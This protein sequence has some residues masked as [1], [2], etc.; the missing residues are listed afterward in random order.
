M[1][2]YDLFFTAACICYNGMF[3]SQFIVFRSFVPFEMK[4]NFLFQG[5][6]NQTYVTRLVKMR[7]LIN[8][9]ACKNATILPNLSESSNANGPVAFVALLYVDGT[10]KETIFDET[11]LIN[12]ERVVKPYE[13]LTYYVEDESCRVEVI[14]EPE[15]LFVTGQVLGFL[16][17]KNTHSLTIKDVIYPEQLEQTGQPE[18]DVICFIADLKI[19]NSM[20]ELNVVIDYISNSKRVTDLVIIGDLFDEVTKE[21]ADLLTQF[22]ENFGAD[23]FIIPNTNDPTNKLLPQQPISNRLIDY[24]CLFL[25]SP[26]QFETGTKM[27]FIPP[28]A[29]NDIKLYGETS[30]IK[31]MK[32]LVRTRHICPTAPDTVG[33]IPY[34]DEDP[35]ILNEMPDYVFTLGDKFEKEIGKITYFVLPSFSKTKKVIILTLDKC[36]FETI[37][38]EY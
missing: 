2:K 16:A 26:A 13:N 10:N 15:G 19:R 22:I 6:Y 37:A 23:T 8:L 3:R 1:L 30:A 9:S 24:N 21:N 29:V 7:P 14:F 35:F 5:Q 33:C 28:V 25:P 4:E 34:K 11:G 18:H 12:K 31:I 36:N 20:G 17:E 32:M 38:L 27:L